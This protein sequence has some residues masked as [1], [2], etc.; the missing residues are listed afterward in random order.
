MRKI[1]KI[2]V[3]CADTRTNQDFS[4]EDI[5]KWHI[6]RGFSREGYHYYIKLNGLIQRGRPIEM[7]GAHCNG[8]NYDSIGICFEGGLND[9]GLMWDEPTTKQ[10]ESFRTLKKAIVSDIGY[11]E[12]YGHYMFSD[13][14][15]CPNFDVCIL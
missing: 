9:K 3:H 8:H 13:E 2:I 15:T 12:V 14:K 11:V 4:I 1:N 7:T 5:K 6:A 10:I